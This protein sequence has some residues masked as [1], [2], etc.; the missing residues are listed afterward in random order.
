[1][2]ERQQQQFSPGSCRHALHWLVCI[3]LVLASLSGPAMSVLSLTGI[4]FLYPISSAAGI[5]KAKVTSNPTPWGCSPPKK[6]GGRPLSPREVA[7]L[8]I[9]PPPE[10][11]IGR[12]QKNCQPQKHFILFIFLNFYGFYGE[13]R[14][15]WVLL[16][17]MQFLGGGKP[18][19][20][21]HPGLCSPTRPPGFGPHCVVLANLARANLEPG[22]GRRAC[23]PVMIE[24]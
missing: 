15:S 7:S 18:T 24:S 19:L 9:C 16:K 17:M 22:I 8:Q 3:W 13:F 14:L 2:V 5:P 1:M 10:D 20:S 12:G 23:I 11:L 6:V 21:S 4:Y